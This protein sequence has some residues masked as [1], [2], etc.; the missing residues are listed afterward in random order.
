MTP[1]KSDN[2]TANENLVPVTSTS[3]SPAANVGAAPE[4]RT[5]GTPATH[6]DAAKATDSDGNFKEGSAF[7]KTNPVVAPTENRNTVSPALMNE[8]PETNATGEELVKNLNAEAGPRVVP[9]Y[10]PVPGLDE[11]N[12]K[13]ADEALKNWNNEVK[14]GDKASGTEEAK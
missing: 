9:P 14:L 11:A 3:T 4:G 13:N 10:N 2:T 8:K 6:E 5:L 12:K 1:E 7:A